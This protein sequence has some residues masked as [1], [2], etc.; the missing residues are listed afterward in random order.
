MVYNEKDS[1]IM[2]KEQTDEKHS[3]LSDINIFIHHLLHF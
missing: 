2:P 1:V 3:Q